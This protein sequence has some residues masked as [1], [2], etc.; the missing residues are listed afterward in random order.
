MT[1]RP[2]IQGL[3]A[4]A[5]LL[6][7]AFHAGLPFPGGFT[8]VDVFFV[9]SGFVITGTLLAE[10]SST[11]R[12]SFSRFYVRRIRRLLPA[13]AL[14]LVFVVLVG[15]L[16]DPVGAQHIAAMTGIFASFFSANGYLYHLGTGYFDVST[17]L[18]P[19]LHTW[20]LA[21]EEQFYVVFPALL[22]AGARVGRSPPEQGRRA[23]RYRAPCARDSIRFGLLR[24]FQ[25]HHGRLRRRD[26]AQRRRR[27]A[28]QLDSGRRCGD[29]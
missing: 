14:V 21:V 19:L 22:A 9:I 2:D 4:L 18:N 12:I 24:R 15:A 16:A 7:I 29:R 11:G 23:R 6:V 1:R 20:T 26:L 25:H 17:A 3:R 8:G 13:L 28:W 10:L 27:L 5:V